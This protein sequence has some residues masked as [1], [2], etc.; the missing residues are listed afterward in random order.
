MFQF[1]RGLPPCLISSGT[2]KISSAS[3]VRQFSRMTD[4]GVP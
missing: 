1:S 3:P 2:R 4:S